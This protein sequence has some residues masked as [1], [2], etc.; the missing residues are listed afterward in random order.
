MI[1][2]NEIQD[3]INIIEMIDYKCKQMF[4]NVLNKYINKFYVLTIRIVERSHFKGI[5]NS[6]HGQNIM[7]C[8]IHNNYK[9]GQP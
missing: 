9:R 6:I 3:N 7:Q 1:Y 2:I 8:F 5:I 4:Y